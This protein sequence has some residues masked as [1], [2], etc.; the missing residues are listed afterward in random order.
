MQSALAHG[1]ES[2]GKR[3]KHTA[4]DQDREQQISDWIQQSTEQSTPVSKNEIKDDWTSQS[5]ASLTRGWVNSFSL[6]HRDDIIQS[7]SLPQ[8]QQR[9]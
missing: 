3:V 2:S 6:R 5:K 7:K 1:L 4:L 9:L 8:E